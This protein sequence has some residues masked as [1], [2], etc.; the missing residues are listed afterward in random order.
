[1]KSGSFYSQIL[2]ENKTLALEFDPPIQEFCTTNTSTSL[3]YI[4]STPNTNFLIQFGISDLKRTTEYQITITIDGQ[5]IET[6]AHR[7]HAQGGVATVRGKTI[8]GEIYPFRFSKIETCGR[9]H[10]SMGK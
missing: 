6:S 7:V 3:A 10:D 2:L 4:Q 1:M 8:K 9:V 5:L